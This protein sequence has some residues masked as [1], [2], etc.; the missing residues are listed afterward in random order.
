MVLARRF[1]G[2]P[3]AAE[4]I[5]QDVERKEPVR[6]E[7]P[8]GVDLPLSPESR[9]VLILAAEEADQL[10]S[11][12]IR[13]EHLLLG[14]L[15]EEGSLAATLLNVRGLHVA[16][17]RDELSRSPHDDSI[18]EEF[19][20]DPVALP[21]GVTESRDRLRSIGSRMAQAIANHDFATARSCSEEERV[22]RDKLRSLSQRHGLSGWMFE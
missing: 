3:W 14:L 15:R 1:L 8:P 4:E 21:D 19:V 6:A 22:E 12:K 9:R 18:V 17:T 13:T 16:S 5:W 2:S 7:I 11:K 20:R 10:S